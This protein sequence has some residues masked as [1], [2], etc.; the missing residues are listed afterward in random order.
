[1]MVARVGIARDERVEGWA[2]V[3]AGGG[4]HVNRR[5][6]LGRRVGKRTIE[7]GITR[8]SSRPHT[9]GARGVIVSRSSLSP[10]LLPPF[11]PFEI[12]DSSDNA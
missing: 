1:M 8:K 7:W 4:W 12:C 3:V 2:G 5:E 11:Y 9:R 10:S 6:S